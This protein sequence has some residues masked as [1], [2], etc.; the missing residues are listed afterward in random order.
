MKITRIDT[1]HIS[2]KSIVHYGQI[3]WTWVRLHTDE[4]IIGTGE[5]YPTPATEV[6]AIHGTLAPVL[7]GQNP[8]EIEHLWH[9]MFFKVQYAGW[10][11]AEMRAISAVNIALWDIF[12]KATHQPIYQLLG[13]KVRDRI[14]TYNTCYDNEFDFNTD[15]GKLAQSLL[16]TGIRAMKIWPF[17]QAGR[18]NQGNFITREQME[19]S[20]EP[21]RQIRAAVG[22]AMDIM[23]EFHA[24]WNLATAVQIAKALEPYNVTWLEEMLPQDNLEAYKVLRARVSQPLNISE[25][26]FGKW[27]YAQ[28]FKQHAASYVMLDLAWCGGLTEAKKI[29]AM[30]EAE[31][32][33]LAPHNCGGPIFHAANLHFAA[34][35]PNLYILESVRRHYQEEYPKIVDRVVVPGPDGCLPLPDGPGLG[36]ELLPE[37]IEKAEI[38]TSM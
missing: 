37:F 38:V 21:V 32:L 11:G 14:R 36:T 12:G 17:D 35:I 15:A 6:A 4:G 23:M 33:P 31:Y 18:E 24:Y 27:Q 30:A 28:L 9:E 22:E 16:K 10:A 29:A 20:L 2:P 34:H 1:L 8:L 3:G 26:L 13:G 25:R 19:A 5:T 7:L